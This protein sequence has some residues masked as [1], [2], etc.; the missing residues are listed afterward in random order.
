M[1]NNI[2]IYRGDQ[3]PEAIRDKR[4][5]RSVVTS[6]TGLVITGSVWVAGAVEATFGKEFVSDQ[7][8][9]GGYLSG[10]A[11]TVAGLTSAVILARSEKTD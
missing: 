6:M 11:L 7:V 9:R 10:G 2:H 5:V 4:I 8:I 3:S 1:S